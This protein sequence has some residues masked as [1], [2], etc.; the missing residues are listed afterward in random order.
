MI[1]ESVQ[2]R[3]DCNDDEVIQRRAHSGS[4]KDKVETCKILGWKDEVGKSRT[5]WV[6]IKLTWLDHME[7]VICR[8]CDHD[9]TKKLIN[10]GDLSLLL[11]LTWILVAS[12]D[13]CNFFF[14]SMTTST[15]IKNVVVSHFKW[16]NLPI[17]VKK[18]IN[19]GDLGLLSLPAW[20]L[21]ASIEW[22]Y[23]V[24][25]L[26]W[27]LYSRLMLWL[28][29]SLYFRSICFSLGS[30]WFLHCQH[31]QFISCSVSR[32]LYIFA[33]FVKKCTL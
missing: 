13:F 20:I 12:I 3:W 19:L 6:M 23:L 25:V 28:L 9:I 5:G 2:R 14:S 16:L 1:A 8:S 26:L 15:F 29:W 11:L 4:E 32:D 33:R 18:L 27:S 7:P 17:N 31:P 22:S 24:L 21:V 10:L 30:L